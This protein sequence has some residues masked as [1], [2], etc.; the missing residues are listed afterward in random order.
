MQ[1]LYK[2]RPLSEF[3]FKELKYQ[4][5]YF[6]NYQELNDPFDL[7][8]R[9]DFSVEK[10]EYVNE[11]VRYL[12]NTTLVLKE[13]K[14]TSQEN[15][16][17]SRLIQ[18]IHDE[19]LC[20]QF[21]NLIFTNIHELKGEDRYLFFDLLETAITQS[22]AALKLKFKFDLVKF[23]DEILRITS[24]F[25]NNSYTTC[26]SEDPANFL[27]WSHYAS[28]HTGICLEFSFDGRA[29]FRYEN[30]GP[31]KYEHG[32]PGD[33]FATGHLPFLEFEGKVSPVL[34]QDE[35]PCI[36]FFDFAAVFAN[37]HDAD[38]I[39]LSKSKWHGYARHLE[40]LF[41]TKTAAWSYEREWRAIDINFG[42]PQQPEERIKHYTVESL[43]AIY[44]GTRTPEAVKQRICHLYKKKHHN[45]K[46]IDCKLSEGKDLNF[47]EW[48]PPEEE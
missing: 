46:L 41:A 19:E 14:Y 3:L 38:L 4:E 39:N 28:K 40:T 12:F 25:L 35:Q 8:V 1:K 15:N 21:E 43:S 24:K 30:F 26:F 9:I 16:N 47:E 34:Y 17:N 36:N 11:L 10:P 48:E 6:A 44:F 5:L 20:T 7:N 45:I 29:G 2:Y 18:F 22:I 42:G 13:G 31:K 32:K 23:K 27:M 33:R 37:E